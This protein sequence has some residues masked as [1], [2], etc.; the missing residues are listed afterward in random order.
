[1][2]RV[3]FLS[4]DMSGKWNWYIT[5][6]LH[7]YIYVSIQDNSISHMNACVLVVNCNNGRI[8]EVFTHNT[9]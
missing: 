6:E 1:M 8:S 3:Q 5:G 4:A 9:V 2:V 7:Q